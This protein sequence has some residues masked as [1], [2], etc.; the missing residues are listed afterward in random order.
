MPSSL[1][2]ESGLPIA[3]VNGGDMAGKV[4]HLDTG[5]TKKVKQKKLVMPKHYKLPPRK[6]AEIMTFLN[7]AHSKGIPPEHLQAT[8]ELK[9]LYAELVSHSESSTEVDLPPN[10]TFSLLPTSEKKARDVFYICGPS[11]SG[12]SYVAK[13]IAQEYHL[14]HPDRPIYI[15]SK[16]T[17]DSTLDKLK[18]L[19]RLDP[20]KLKDQPLENLKDLNESLVIFDDIENFDKETDK[21]I[22]NLVN[23]IASTGRHENVSMIYITH[24][25]SDYKRTRLVLMEATQYVL[26]PL[27]TGSHAF[28]YMMKTYLG[29]DSKEANALRKTGSRWISIRKH[30]PQVLITEHSAKVMNQ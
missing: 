7:D 12:K 10:S 5:D 15:V 28:N 4:L 17:E 19:V 22:Q 6:E 24:L 18:Y 30:F 20:T 8:V 13:G 14:M 23:M 3:K 1:N 29:M 21:A 25:L 11:G 9:E 2:F 27:S 16:L 26:Y